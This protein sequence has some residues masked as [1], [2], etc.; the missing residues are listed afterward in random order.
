MNRRGFLAL[1]GLSVAATGMGD[2][3][4]LLAQTRSE[5]AGAAGETT[6][7]RFRGV[8]AR[9]VHICKGVPYG[10]STAGAGRFL[11]PRK[12]EPWAGVRNTSEYGPRAY[13]PFRPMIP[14]IGDALT[15]SG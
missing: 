7:G 4:R 14:E 6:A 13:Q 3:A 9:G 10:A 5:A 8:V 1:S 2:V 11:P 15:G 12:P